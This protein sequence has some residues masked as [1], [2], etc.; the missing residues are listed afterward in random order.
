MLHSKECSPCTGGDT[1]LGV[2]VLCVVAYGLLRD[3]EKPGYLLFRVSAR[4]KP[5]NLDFAFGEASHHFMTGRA[6]AMARSREHATHS[7]AIE[8]PCTRL[9]AQLFG[10]SLWRQGG[11]VGAWLG[12]CMVDV[13]GGEYSSRWRE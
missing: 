4:E 13:G 12:H 3:E 9:L 2:D 7:F 5:Q 11:P 6:N 1:N 10:G 8:F